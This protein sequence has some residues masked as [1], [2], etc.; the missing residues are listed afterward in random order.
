VYKKESFG[1]EGNVVFYASLRTKRREG[2]FSPSAQKKKENFVHIKALLIHQWK[3]K[4]I[5]QGMNRMTSFSYIYK[6]YLKSFSSTVYSLLFNLQGASAS[7]S[8][9][10]HQLRL[11]HPT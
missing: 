1:K 2:V 11:R 3:D 5:L 8:F 4:D 7:A 9:S 6:S 10:N